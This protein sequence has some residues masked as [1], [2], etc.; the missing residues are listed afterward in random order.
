MF[1]LAGPIQTARFISVDNSRLVKRED[2]FGCKS[3]RSARP[4]RASFRELL[5]ND[6]L[7]DNR[8]D[9]RDDNAKVLDD[10]DLDVRYLTDGQVERRRRDFFLKK[11]MLQN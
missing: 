9:F 7:F 2:F 11:A 5:A 4:S 6:A 1:E 8:G 3:S 10:Y